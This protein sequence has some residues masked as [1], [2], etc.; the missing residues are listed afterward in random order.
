MHP[1][2]AYLRFTDVAKSFGDVVALDGLNLEIAAGE[3]FVLLGPSGCGKS[4]AIQLANRLMDPDAGVITVADQPI[5]DIDPVQLRRKIGYVIQQ[6]G[7]FPHRTVADNVGT[8]CRLVGWNRSDTQ[9]RVETLMDLVGLPVEEY[10]K[11]YPNELSGGQQQRVGVARALAVDPPLLLMDEPF[12]A[13]DPQIRRS[14]QVEFRSWVERLGTTVLFVS[15][16]VD[17]ALVLADRIGVMG[18]RGHLDQVGTPLEVLSAPVNDQVRAFLG[19]ERALKRLSV[20]AINVQRLSP[21]RSASAPTVPDDASVQTALLALLT[22]DTDEI[23]LLRDE[24]VLGAL[25]LGDIGEQARIAAGES[26]PQG[27]QLGEL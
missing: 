18:T 13:L 5:A 11:R 17:E 1:R 3:V 9:A 23:H 15:H 6:I 19:P 2:H 27:A 24:T 20:T 22:N 16:D 4:T 10:G 26:D 25:T 14:L 7:L 8:V 12:A 21:V